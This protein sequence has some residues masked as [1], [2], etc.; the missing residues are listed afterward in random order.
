MDLSFL[1]QSCT[2]PYAFLLYQGLTLVCFPMEASY[3]V[4]WDHQILISCLWVH[5]LML[6]LCNQIEI[7]CSI[8]VSDSCFANSCWSQW[9]L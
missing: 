3:C 8:F 9:D 1:L 4:W 6:I 7:I 2:P 5:Q